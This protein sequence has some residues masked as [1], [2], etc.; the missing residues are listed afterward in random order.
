VC[1]AGITII[2]RNRQVMLRKRLMQWM[3]PDVSGQ[4]LLRWG[5]ISAYISLIG[6]VMVYINAIKVGN[7]ATPIRNAL[8]IGVLLVLLLASDVGPERVAAELAGRHAA[9]GD[10]R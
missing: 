1:Y 5:F 9:A 10:P 3:V 8:G 6:A 4:G 7:C 2:F